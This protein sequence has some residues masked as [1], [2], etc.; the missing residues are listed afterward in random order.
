MDGVVVS[1]VTSVDESAMTGEAMPVAK[2]PGSA[3]RAGTANCEGAVD[4]RVERA[5]ADTAIADVVRQVDLAQARAAPIQRI[6]DAGEAA[7]ALCCLAVSGV[8][9]TTH[10]GCLMSSPAP[11]LLIAAA[12]SFTYGVL[13]A[14]AATFSFW[15]LV[16]AR[17]FPRALELG[18][19]GGLIQCIQW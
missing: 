2:R 9:A 10:T 18:P 3:V 17:T 4:V 13:A 6:A 5:G 12:G 1:G 7:P 15:R 11:P 14:S 19:R 8:G 16:G